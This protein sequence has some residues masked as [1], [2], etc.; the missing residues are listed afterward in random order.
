MLAHFF[1]KLFQKFRD[2]IMGQ[3][4]INLLEE[5]TLA[6]AQEHVE[7][8]SLD[9]MRSGI[10]G[11]NPD[12][13]EQRKATFADI[14]RGGSV[15]KVADMPNTLVEKSTRMKHFGSERNKLVDFSHFQEIIPS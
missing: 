8:D 15:S 13:K 11:K 2:V 12:S 6:P 14:V 4:H 10:N 1:T 9:V 5:A 7:K 3:M